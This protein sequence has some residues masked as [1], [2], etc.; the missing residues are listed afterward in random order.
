MISCHNKHLG[1]TKNLNIKVNK[2]YVKE[3]DQ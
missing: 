2:Y 1:M 3:Y